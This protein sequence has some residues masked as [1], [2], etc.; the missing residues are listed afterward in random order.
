MQLQTASL[1]E[2]V[3]HSDMNPSADYRRIERAIRYLEQNFLDQPSLEELAGNSGLSPFH[4]QRLFKRWAGISP[5]R[6]LQFL[7][8]EYA[9]GL[10]EESHTLLDTAYE[11]GLS[12]PGRLHDLFVKIEAV[13]P[14]EYK[15]SG[16]GVKIRFGFHDSPFG[17]CLIAV[18]DRGIC[19]LSF[20]S[21]TREEALANLLNRWPGAKLIEDAKATRPSAEKIFSPAKEKLSL[22]L[23]GTNFQIKVWE[24]LLHVP[25]GRLCCY[26]DL[27]RAVGE[28]A[29]SRAVGSAVGANPVAFLIPCHRVIRKSGIIG[30]YRW[31]TARKKAML[32]WEAALAAGS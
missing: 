19:G 6:F 14:A 2:R 16:A 15:R 21:A 10:L 24:A 25:S 27:A 22:F 26:E 3:M 23:K 12:G 5:K 8:V 18:T 28:P 13:T 1:S 7:T 20:A 17:E 11:A 31:G 29:A 30:S 32:A 4:F 9:K